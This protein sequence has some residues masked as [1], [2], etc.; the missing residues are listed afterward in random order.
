[1]NGI[2]K[3]IGGWFAAVATTVV[4]GIIFQTQMGLTRLEGVGA[5]V[6]FADR[7]SMT[8]YDIFYLGQFYFL[9][10]GIALAIAFLAGGLIFRFAQFGRPLIYAV[11]GS[12]ALLIML[13][14]M[15]QRFF[16]VHIINGA[17]DAV[18]MGLQMIAGALG[19]VVFTVVNRP[20]KKA[21][22]KT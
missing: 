5:D 8:G 4:L 12:A 11:A 3:R 18:G 1:M 14:L 15:K 21:P 19:G 6:G 17:K 13:F 20:T 9:F 10:V 7:V 22:T 16:D 2:I